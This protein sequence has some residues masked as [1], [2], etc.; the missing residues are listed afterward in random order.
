MGKKT[1]PFIP[2]C[3]PYYPKIALF[4]LFLFSTAEI[5]SDTEA[6]REDSIEYNRF[7]SALPQA[8]TKNKN[9]IKFNAVSSLPKVKGTDIKI[10][11]SL[12]KEKTE[13]QK[14]T[15]DLFILPYNADLIK[16]NPILI[17][18]QATGTLKVTFLEE[19]NQKKN[20]LNLNKYATPEEPSKASDPSIQRIVLEDCSC[21]A[22]SD[23]KTEKIDNGYIFENII[24]TSPLHTIMAKIHF[25]NM[26]YITSENLLKFMKKRFSMN[27]DFNYE[28][29][30]NKIIE[31]DFYKSNTVR[32]DLTCKNFS[33]RKKYSSGALLNVHGYAF[34]H[35][36]DTHRIIEIS[37]SDRYPIGYVPAH[38]ERYESVC[39]TF[40]KSIQFNK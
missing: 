33:N 12:N 27:N 39:E 25:Y 22:F 8:Y 10:Y 15:E 1:M 36:N 26:K 30:S 34:I 31:T 14:E 20:P 11:M 6:P 35:P 38:P 40:L 24:S 5:F 4:I 7:I 29:I 28:V 13:L 9:E 23:W 17:M 2:K 18:N 37:W 32:Y 19:N 21:L 16:Q 3:S